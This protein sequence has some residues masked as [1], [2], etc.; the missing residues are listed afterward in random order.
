MYICLLKVSNS[1]KHVFSRNGKALFLAE[2][3]VPR[4]LGRA[5]VGTSFLP[6][7]LV[8]SIGDSGPLVL[9]DQ[10]L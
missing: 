10:R 7:L 1:K 2:R 6:A 5:I 9:G 4:V 8:P 3:G